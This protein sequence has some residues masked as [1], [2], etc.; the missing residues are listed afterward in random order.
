M[1]RAIIL[2]LL[3]VPACDIG[4]VHDFPR[5]LCPEKGAV[6]HDFTDFHLPR[7][8]I[9]ATQNEDPAAGIPGVALPIVYEDGPESA[10]A[11]VPCIPGD[12]VTFH[13]D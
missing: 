11:S 12:V 13:V 10:V 2:A 5:V 4:G 8:S 7:A 1:K 3:L 6:V 9:T